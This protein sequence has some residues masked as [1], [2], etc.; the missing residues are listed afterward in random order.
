[1]GVLVHPLLQHGLD[2][3]LPWQ[4]FVPRVDAQLVQHFEHVAYPA[5][6]A[7]FKVSQ[8]WQTLMSRYVTLHFIV[9]REKNR[10]L[11]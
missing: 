2:V 8:I 4:S 7:N 6:E 5:L 9:M 10:P 1:M 3:H 11:K